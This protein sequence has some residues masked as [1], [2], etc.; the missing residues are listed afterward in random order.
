[1]L[2]KYLLFFLFLTVLSASAKDS[3]FSSYISLVGMS[4]NYREYSND[5]VLLDS[6]ESSYVDLSGIE[7]AFAYSFF[8]STPYSSKIK[9]NYM[10]LSGGTKYIGSYM[11]SD[12]PYGSVVSQTHNNI[13][14][15]DISYMGSASLG[16]DFQFVYGVGLGYREWERALSASQIEVYSWYSARPMLGVAANLNESFELGISVEYQYGFEEKMSESTLN[17]TFILGEADILELSLALNY[18]YNKSINF[19][20]EAVFQE[21]IIIESDK[22]YTSDGTM[23][24][25][26]PD[27]TA[28]NSYLKFAIGYMF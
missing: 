4:M 22:L 9:F 13:I 28:Y 3:V 8:Q 16:N 10:V 12:L 14:D 27:S 7:L 25:Y 26:E 11:N 1:M 5:K 21:Q 15:T 19:T 23:Y 17:H 18:L 20:F 6:E 2:K 24:Y